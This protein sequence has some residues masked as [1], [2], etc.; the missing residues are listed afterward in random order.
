MSTKIYNGI[1]FKNF[2][3]LD[4]ALNWCVKKQPSL[5][6]IAIELFEKK[7]ISQYFEL[8]DNLSI[9]NDRNEL[10]K[11]FE[12][13][14][15]SNPYSFIVDKI[16]DDVEKAEKS[17]SR[18]ESF[19]LDFSSSILFFKKQKKI[20]G[21]YLAEDKSLIDYILKDKEVSD[22]HYQNSTDRP[23]NISAKDWNE[24]K[25]VWNSIDIPR[26]E[27]LSFQFTSY[28]DL[29]YHSVTFEN[30]RSNFLT[31]DQRAEKI[32]SVLISKED[33]YLQQITDSRQWY[34][35]FCKSQEWRKTDEAKNILSNIKSE[36]LKSLIPTESLKYETLEKNI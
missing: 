29:Q 34:E 24:R 15:D 10:V 16:R 14:K 26:K 33:P 1:I 6:K 9:K 25:A 27:G 35:L 8:I 2:N 12:K 4:Q 31:T 17:S 36:V 7:I 13:S 20:I 18:S 28:K 30:L 22:Y 3:T 11:M 21:Y 23:E 5:E 32:A 19:E